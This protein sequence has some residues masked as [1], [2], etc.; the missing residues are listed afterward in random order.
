VESEVTLAEYP[1]FVQGCWLLPRT[2]SHNPG[3]TG[4]DE[5]PAEPQNF[6][7]QTGL[8]GASPSHILESPLALE[9]KICY[10]YMTSNRFLGFLPRFCPTKKNLSGGRICHVIPNSA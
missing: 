9:P 4:R 10:F 6:P 8:A 7:T 1:V 3:A 2:K 5:A